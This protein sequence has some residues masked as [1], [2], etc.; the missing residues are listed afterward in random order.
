VKIYVA[1]VE[2]L[3]ERQDETQFITKFDGFMSFTPCWLLIFFE[4]RSMYDQI[5]GFGAM[6]SLL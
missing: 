6:F 5:Q 2:M 3:K 4:S 1:I